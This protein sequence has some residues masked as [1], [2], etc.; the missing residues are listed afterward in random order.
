MF[1][2]F[3]AGEEAPVPFMAGFNSG[4]FRAFE[5]VLPPLPADAAAYRATVCRR[6]GRYLDVGLAAPEAPSLDR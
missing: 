1:E 5:G 6:Y 3:E 4:E 2:G